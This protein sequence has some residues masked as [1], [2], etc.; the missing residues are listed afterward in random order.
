MAL[1]VLVEH[2]LLLVEVLLIGT[3]GGIEVPSR[4]E[5]QRLDVFLID[6]IGL[7]D[8]ARSLLGLG[9]DGPDSDHFL[10]INKL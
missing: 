8:P 10:P 6:A 4:V 5:A 7:L 3:V 9:D 1:P 2:P